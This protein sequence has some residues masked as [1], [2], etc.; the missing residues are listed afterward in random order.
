MNNSARVKKR[1]SISATIVI[2]I[3]AALVFNSTFM[4]LLSWRENRSVIL[5]QNAEKA[6]MVAQTMAAQID[7]V[8]YEA[9]VLNG[10]VDEYWYEVRDILD[11]VATYINAL[12]AYVLITHDSNVVTYFMD[13]DT[14]LSEHDP[15]DLFDT[16]SVE[17]FAHELLTAMDNAEAG[18]SG[19]LDGGEFGLAVAGFAPVISADGRFLGMVVFEFG[20]DDVLAPVNRFAIFLA[21]MAVAFATAIAIFSIIVV[22]ARLTKPLNTLIN[23]SKEIAHG[24]FNV[25]M[26]LAKGDEIGVLVHDF[27]E[28]VVSINTV[29]DDLSNVHHN[30]NMLGNLHYRIDTGKYQNSFKS[31]TEN[32]NQILEAQTEDVLRVADTLNQISVGNFDIKIVDL[33]GDFGVQSQ[34][35][36]SV[37]ANLKNISAEVNSMIVAAAI[38]GDLRFQIDADKYKGDWRDIMKGLNSFAKAVDTPVAE[39]MDVMR[40]LSQGDFSSLVQGDYKGGYLE[41]KNAVNGTIKTLSGYIDEITDCLSHISSGDL[42][43]SISR[44]Y[45]GSFNAIKDSLNNISATL[46]KT[47]A[48]ISAASEHVLQ[49]AQQISN[50][51]STL[52]SGALEQASFVQE[53]NATIDVISHQA[54]QNADSALTANEL[55]NKS[56]ANADEGNTAMRQTVEAMMQIKESSGNIS[57]IVKTIQDI[58]FQT[59][60]LALNAAVEAARAGDAGRGFAVVAEE[61]RSLAGRSQEAATETTSLIQDSI[62]RVESGSSIA[63]S[64]AKS[65]DAIVASASEVLE[66]I[67]KISAASKEQTEAITS[68]SD[69]L[70]QI[71]KVTQD[72]TDVSHATATASEE[73]NAQAE[74]LRQL[75]AFFKL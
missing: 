9:I 55:S 27:R 68:V 44:E 43:Y 71:S 56:T 73:L 26:P 65:L 42:T 54:K 66:I 58:A 70:V 41:I 39:I 72:N 48:E 14:P 33:P 24:N 20:V 29:V 60:L 6:M 10:E 17:Y 51:A 19:I 57:K 62:S 75:V 1:L 21:L 53:L 16:L 30:Y 59:N 7:P 63:Q 34:A 50:S 18:F 31:M 35:L 40:K 13:A 61:V 2:L 15:L 5:A 3:L 64:T 28:L 22:R 49:G 38:K 37:I 67:S 23:V 45:V 52:S 74:V 46:N 25:N 32:V 12:Y 4:V 36:H 8:R 69:G 11:A 47:M